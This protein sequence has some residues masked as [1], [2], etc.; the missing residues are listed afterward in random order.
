MHVLSETDSYSR[1]LVLGERKLCLPVGEQ[2]PVPVQCRVGWLH[3]SCASAFL[4]LHL[5]NVS[6]HMPTVLHPQ[7]CALP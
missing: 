6:V 2:I 1:C 3:D 5:L 7:P 4:L